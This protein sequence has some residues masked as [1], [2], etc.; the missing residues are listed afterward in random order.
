MQHTYESLRLKYKPEHITFLLIAESPPPSSFIQSSRQ[1]YYTDHIR[2]DDRLF[3]NTIRALYPE[4]LETPEAELEEHKEE[5]LE[6]FKADGV[7]RT[8][9]TG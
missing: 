6:R 4:T 2:K 7:A 9:E 8:Y 1:F 3:V 5:W